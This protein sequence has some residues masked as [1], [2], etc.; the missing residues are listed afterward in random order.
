MKPGLHVFHVYA[1]VT[2]LERDRVREMAALEGLT[3]SDFVRRCVNTYLI[4][5][6]DQG[7]LLVEQ[8]DRRGRPKAKS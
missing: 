8:Q 7:I 6:D 5:I 1:Q 4:E 2:E 3:M